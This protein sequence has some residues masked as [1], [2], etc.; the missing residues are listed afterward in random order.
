MKLIATE[1]SA[2]ASVYAAHGIG[3]TLEEKL[4]E[5]K[6]SEVDDEL[7]VEYPSS[8]YLTAKASD[9][10]LDSAFRLTAS[11]TQV[12]IEIIEETTTE[13]TAVEADST[14]IEDVIKPITEII[15]LREV[16]RKTEIIDE[17]AVEGGNKDSSTFALILLF[18]LVVIAAITIVFIIVYNKKNGSSLCCRRKIKIV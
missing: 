2:G 13:T 16:E 15:Q 7:T 18:I 14:A 8:V 10:G 9:E 11:Y 6:F 4:E 5:V 3:F 12:V 1:M 17:P